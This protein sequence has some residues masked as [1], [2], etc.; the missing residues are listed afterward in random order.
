M[1]LPILTLL[2]AG[3]VHASEPDAVRARREA[4]VIEARNGHVQEGLDALR[5]LLQQYPEDARLLA[6]TEIVA[7]WAGNDEL[8]LEL[9]ARPLTPKDDAG[10]V[11]TAARAARNLHAYEQAVT[12]Y[13]R[14][15]ALEPERWQSQL[16]EAMTL[17]DQGDYA[18]AALLMRP[19]LV[20]HREERDV[21]LGQAYLCSRLGDFTCSVAMD[22]AYLEKYPDDMQ[23]KSDLALTLSH[24]GDQTLAAAYY[25]A[26][27][28]PS[29][30]KVANGLSGAEGG[31]EV[32]WGEEF[33]PNRAQQRAES[34]AALARLD[35]VVQASTPGELVWR[36]AQFD[37]MVVLHDLYRMHEVVDLY[38]TLKRQGMETPEYALRD[39]AGAYLSLREPE[40]A[41]ELYRQLLQHDTGD[42]FIW[43]GLAYAQLER[44][45]LNESLETIDEAYREAPPWLRA[46]ALHELRPNRIRIALE[47]QAAQMRCDVDL[48]K[49]CQE[50]LAKLSDAVPGNAQVRWDLAASELARG[51]DERALR[52]VR[53]AN[54]YARRMS[55]PR[56]RA[57]RFTKRRVCGT[58]WTA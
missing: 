13:R 23:V 25:A 8:V 27:V 40:R 17:T 53:I 52:E 24:V 20:H 43:S 48:L 28:A 37:R 35:A 5:A 58:M 4:A 14:A 1:C 19:L 10:V 18:T 55:F 56:W 31:E 6:D 22:E 9:Y 12:L 50:R 3:A 33:A 11:E 34:E 15:E 57:P 30:S 29:V 21:L 16:G 2:I 32:G 45:H 46:V 36:S 7:G 26:E 42:G 38:E 51:W 49:E 44:E 39:V 47:A 54:V 41:E